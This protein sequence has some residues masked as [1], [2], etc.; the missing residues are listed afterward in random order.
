MDDKAKMEDLL[1]SVKGVCDLYLHGTI[2]SNTANV[3]GA[4]D[5]ALNESLKMQS[6]IY[7]KMEEKGWYPT[8]KADQKRIQQVKQKYEGKMNA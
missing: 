2:E 8:D 5:E 6:E 4:F 7:K 1:M 3:H